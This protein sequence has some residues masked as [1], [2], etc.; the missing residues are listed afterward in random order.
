MSRSLRVLVVSLVVLVGGLIVPT[1]AQAAPRFSVLVFSK[2]NGFT[3]DSI[4]A[5][6]AAI[7]ELGSQNNFAVTVSDDAAL[8][9]DAGLAPFDAVIFNNTNGRDGAVLDTNQRAALQRY[10]RAGNGFAGIH[11]ASGSDRD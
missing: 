9:T 11:S 8:F 4:P 5:G 2:V 6:K 10:V 1:A 3:H 7:T